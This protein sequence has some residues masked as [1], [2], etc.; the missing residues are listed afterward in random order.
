MLTNHDWP[1]LVAAIAQTRD[2]SAFATIFDYFVPR[3]EAYLMRL[4][5]DAGSAEEVSQDAMIALWN[6]AHLFD[7]AK[8][9]FPTWI[10]RIARNRRIDV[11]RRNRLD[12]FD[13][14]ESALKEIADPAPAQDTTMDGQHREDRVREALKLLPEE[15]VSLIQLAFFDGL[16]HSEVAERTG[17]P[18]GTVKS[19]IRLAFTRLRR[20][21][22]A[23]GVVEAG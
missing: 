18:L 20:T 2:R 10:Y 5:M 11:S 9:S 17:L 22:E 19:R 6:K 16:S 12:Y 13:P 3:L 8:S 21:L 23:E 15:Q 1:K 7:P 14:T 4:G